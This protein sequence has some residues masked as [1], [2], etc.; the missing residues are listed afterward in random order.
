[1]FGLLTVACILA[2]DGNPSVTYIHGLALVL[3]VV[4]TIA[5]ALK[6]SRM[7]PK[8]RPGFHVNWCPS[9]V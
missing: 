9:P 6:V 4:G 3:A 5:V 1:M 7:H 8:P 2:V